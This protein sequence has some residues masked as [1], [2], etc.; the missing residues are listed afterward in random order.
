MEVLSWDSLLIIKKTDVVTE[1]KS[2]VGKDEASKSGVVLRL[3]RSL[4]GVRIGN[5]Q[6]FK[7][8]S[9]QLITPI[10]YSKNAV[11]PMLER[12]TTL[13]NNLTLLLSR[14]DIEPYASLDDA[15][16][17]PSRFHQPISV[18]EAE[19]KNLIIT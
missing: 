1:Q 17:A 8:Y 16:A 14:A 2:D 10:I 5:A 13:E 6:V 4:G 19:S 7:L 12:L 3:I 11:D 9:L 15:L 18:K